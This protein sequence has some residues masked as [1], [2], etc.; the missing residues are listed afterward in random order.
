MKDDTER[1]G[2]KR[3]VDD[4]EGINFIDSESYCS[5]YLKRMFIVARK[6]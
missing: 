5:R 1:Q 3:T 4:L 2:R 6:S